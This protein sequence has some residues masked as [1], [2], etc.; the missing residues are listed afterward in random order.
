MLLYSLGERYLLKELY[1]K[2]LLLWS[3]LSHMLKNASF[4]PCVLHVRIEIILQDHYAEK[5][6]CFTSSL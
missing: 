6:N 2:I 1:S 5:F 3:V 4:L